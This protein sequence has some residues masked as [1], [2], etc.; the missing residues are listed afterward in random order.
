M[1]SNIG[2]EPRG[3][4]ISYQGYGINTPTDDRTWTDEKLGPF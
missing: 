1:Y 3:E 2:I 4:I